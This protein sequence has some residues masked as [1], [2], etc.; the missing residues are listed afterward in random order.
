[1]R[2]REFS[3][4]IARA[5]PCLVVCACSAGTNGPDK[6]L[7]ADER[8]RNCRSVQPPSHLALHLR[9][10]FR[11]KNRWIASALTLDRTGGNRWTS[12]NWKPTPPTPAATINTRM[13]PT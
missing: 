8:Q 11:D 7:C 9:N 4:A 6:V 3:S 5:L 12:Y 1:M 2:L 13:T 10:Q